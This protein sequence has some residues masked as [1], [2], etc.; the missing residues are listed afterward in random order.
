MSDQEDS[1]A[2]VTP[3][4]MI[5]DTVDVFADQGIIT[6]ETEEQVKKALDGDTES[7]DQ[8]TEKFADS[9]EDWISES[10]ES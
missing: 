8:L 4:E 5:E 3:A 6:E 2:G 7:V 9:L 1:D 10:D